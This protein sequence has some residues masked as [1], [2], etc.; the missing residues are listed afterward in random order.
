MTTTTMT[1]TR[2]P[3]IWKYV[4]RHGQ[5]RRPSR[6]LVLYDKKHSRSWMWNIAQWPMSKNQ[7]AMAM[8]VGTSGRDETLAADRVIE[9]RGQA[10]VNIF[11]QY[12]FIVMISTGKFA[13]TYLFEKRTG[14]NWVVRNTKSR[15]AYGLQKGD[16]LLT[17][18]RQRRGVQHVFT[19][20]SELVQ[21]THYG[22]AALYA[23]NGQVIDHD[24]AHGTYIKGMDEILTNNDVMAV[25]PNT[26]PRKRAEAVRW[27]QRRQGHPYSMKSLFT[28]SVY[29][30]FISEKQP[31]KNLDDKEYVC[32]GVVASAYR[33][34]GR[35]NPR[36]SVVGTRPSD[37]AASDKTTMIRKYAM[38]IIRGRKL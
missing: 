19:P 4:I 8:F 18:P 21:G 9:A 26:T 11:G 22:H 37:I 38:Y 3:E 12:E 7:Q 16:I 1:P 17:G 24:L 25:R 14:D 35:F 33:D 34:I 6:G 29:P 28:D 13:G 31:D 36:R 32:S 2:S 10:K 20:V 27:A 5:G 23:G 30:D 15:D